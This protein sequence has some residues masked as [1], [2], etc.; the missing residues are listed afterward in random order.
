MPETLRALVV[1]DEALARANLRHAIREFP[2][3]EVVA[4]CDSAASARAALGA[5]R[6][7][8]VF[9]DIQMPGE[10]GLTLARE[11]TAVGS[12]PIIVFVTAYDEFAIEAFEVQ[13]L[14]YL[15]KPFD[16]G[17]LAQT[18]TRAGELVRL[19]QRAPWQ[20]AVDDAV[21]AVQAVR[22]Q[23]LVVPLSRVCV[24]SVGH[25]ETVA[26]SAVRWIAS[27]GNYVELHLGGRRVL[28]RV[29]LA[30]L[31]AHLD[32]E[33]FMRVHRTAIVRRAAI[34]A[35]RV[36]GDGTYELTLDRGEVVPV[37]ERHVASVRTLLE[38]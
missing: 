15:Q 16:D 7:D 19:R 1:D 23:G 36:T 30:R 11:L 12:A 31:E 5:T 27:A 9:L 32:A 33:V 26:I 17:R 29:T 14:D 4:E 22:G 20:A 37:S 28:H 10:N 8:V 6:V 34:A 35:L 13:A 38:T 18:L 24:R 25:I 3:W 2:G 21:S